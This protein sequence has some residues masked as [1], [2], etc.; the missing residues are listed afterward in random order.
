ME[1]RNGWRRAMLAA[2]HCETTVLVGPDFSSATLRKLAAAE[3]PIGQSLT[4]IAVDHHWVSQA[5]SARS[6]SYYLG[7]RSWNRSAFRIARRLHA[8]APFDLTHYV[9]FCGFREPGLLWKLGTPFVWGPVGGTQNLPAAFLGRLGLVAAIKEVVRSGLNYW[10]LRFSPRVRRAAAVCAAPLAATSTAQRHMEEAWGR[11]PQRQLETG[12]D[13]PITPPRPLR[14]ASQ[15]LRILWA[16]RLQPWKG[17]P[18]LA[19]AVASLPASVR[20]EVRVVGAGPC[21]QGWRRLAEQLGINQLIEWIDWPGYEG[22]LEHYRWADIF[23][24]TSLRDT[25][26][27]GLLEALAAGAPIVGVDHQG[28]ADV[29]TPECAIPVTVSNPRATT[30]ALAEAITN[31][32]G[33]SVRL[34]KL[35]HG[36]Q[37]RAADYDWEQRVEFTQS[38]YQHALESKLPSPANALDRRSEVFD[39][40]AFPATT[41]V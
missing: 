11:K 41:P 17:F 28:A 36:A 27:T 29:M 33:D 16:G 3:G 10:Q 23:A 18:L 8:Q 37:R 6:F 4:F 9:N 14:D 34:R 35:S 7:Y 24:F 31:L 21:R 13:C 15:P 32:A 39:P 40:T 1:S 19:D 30:A 2:R 12:L 20:V 38:L 25:S 22:T 5:L 26:G